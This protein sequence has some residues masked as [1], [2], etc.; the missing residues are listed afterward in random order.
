MTIRKHSIPVVLILLVLS[1][2]PSLTAAGQGST[3]D[4][5]TVEIVNVDLF[6]TDRDGRLIRG[7][8]QSHFEVLEDKKKV[9]ITN[10]YFAGS[11]DADPQDRVKIIVYVDNYNSRAPSRNASL[12]AMGDFLE[13]Q[14]TTNGLEVMVVTATAGVE[15][16]QPLTDS[17]AD[18]R[19]ILDEVAADE[20]YGARND[21]DVVRVSQS[22]RR[23]DYSAGRTASA[24]SSG[25]PSAGR[26]GIVGG[27]VGDPEGGSSD[28]EALN[29]ITGFAGTVFQET[30]ATL[31]NL[32]FFVS[33]LGAIPG[34]KALFYIS[35]GLV[36]MP[37]DKLARGREG[38]E[39]VERAL[40]GYDMSGR[41]TEI[42]ALANT[43][44]VTIYAINSPPA[45]AAGADR[46][47]REVSDLSQAAEQMSEHTGGLYLATR[48]DVS[49][50]LAE[51]RGDF[52]GFY[53]LGYAPR[54]K[55]EDAF[56]AIR[57]KYKG[58]GKSKGR[59][60]HRTSYIYK[61][62]QG[63]FADMTVG[64]ILLGD[65]GNQHEMEIQIDSQEENEDGT[66]NVSLVL[67]VPIAN[68]TLLE[69][70]GVHEASAQIAIAL[71]IETGGIAPV[72]FLRIPLRIPEA[73]LEAA[74][75]QL[76]AGRVN[77]RLPGGR[78]E[79]ALGLWDQAS[80]E[81]SFLTQELLIE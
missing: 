12:D 59:L 74:R 73:D 29:I 61:S 41:Y 30:M 26:A 6:V 54:D 58:K 46:Y 79:V 43:N 32:T 4:T 19:A 11:K 52:D 50:F 10:F 15:V 44:R 67:M 5:T 3:F 25:V 65:S 28:N 71:R 47:N 36:T 14:M 23:Q 16:R 7:L 40:G 75:Q 51:V 55:T 69:S 70:A 8:D 63:R 37:V 77:L 17:I 22:A 34:R 27:Q 64:S 42:T 72:Q 13:N 1:A 31:D 68:L 35:D 9:E 20:A 45:D 18:M 48:R 60:R 81:T 80:N 49:S 62:A 38:N 57:V 78:H 21:E 33:T 24:E 56:H 39:E 76:Y 53:S 2:G 66:F